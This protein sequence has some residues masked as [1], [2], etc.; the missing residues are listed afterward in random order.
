MGEFLGKGGRE[1]SQ[2]LKTIHVSREMEGKLALGH[3]LLQLCFEAESADPAAEPVL[4]T[5][6]RTCGDVCEK[7]EKDL[8]ALSS[9]FFSDRFWWFMESLRGERDSALTFS[10]V[11]SSHMDI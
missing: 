5:C 7:L 8:L 1:K 3:E 4:I 11:S 6:R 9:C 2:G 10:A